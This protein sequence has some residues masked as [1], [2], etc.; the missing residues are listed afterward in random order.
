[1]TRRLYQWLTFVIAAFALALSSAVVPA[2]QSGTLLQQ[3]TTALGSSTLTIEFEV[4]GLVGAATQT[5]LTLEFGADGNGATSP[6]PTPPL[7][8]AAVFTVITSTSADSL[9][10]S[11]KGGA[12]RKFAGKVVSLIRLDPAG[13]PALYR[14][15]VVHPSEVPE[16]TKEVWKVVINGLPQTKT[17][18]IGAIKQGAFAS[19][20][21]IGACQ[22]SSSPSGTA[23]RQGVT[24][25]G[26]ANPAIG[27]DIAGP[28]DALTQTTL[29]LEFGT[30]GNRQLPA[31]DPAF[32]G[33][34]RMRISTDISSDNAS[35]QLENSEAAFANKEIRL[36]RLSRSLYHLVIQHR[37][38]VPDRTTEKW[39]VELTDMP[40]ATLRAIGVV[41]QGTV[42]S[43]SPLGACQDPPRIDIEPRSITAGVTVENVA[44]TTPD[45]F[46][47][48][49]VSNSQ[50]RFSPENIVTKATIT[51]QSRKSL[52]LSVLTAELTQAQKVT[53]AVTAN[54]VTSQPVTFEVAPRPSISIK[55]PFVMADGRATL[56]ITTDSN[57]FDLS[58]GQ[59]EITPP[60]IAS[61]VSVTSA[62]QRA[63]TV[64]VSLAAVDKPQNLSLTVTANNVRS[65]QATF[66]VRPR[67]RITLSPESGAGPATVASGR[68]RRFI[69]TS[70]EGFDLRAVSELKFTRAGVPDPAVSN[71]ALGERTERNA[72]LV[73]DLASDAASG[74]WELTLMANNVSASGGFKVVAIA[75]GPAAV[76]PGRSRTLNVVSSPGFDLRAVTNREVKFTRA[77]TE[78]SAISNLVLSNRMEGSLTLSFDVASD[79]PVGDRNLSITVG[80]VEASTRFKVA[81]VGVSQPVVAPGRLRELTIIAS[82]GFDLRTASAVKFTRAGKPDADFSNATFRNQAERSLTLSFDVSDGAPAGDRELTITVNNVD[83]AASFRLVTISAAVPGLIAMPSFTGSVGLRIVSSGGFDLSNAGQPTINPGSGISDVTV[84]SA[85]AGDVTLSFTVASEAPPGDR[86]LIITANNVRASAR[87]KLIR[88]RPDPDQM[89]TGDIKDVKITASEGFSLKG[90]TINQVSV[91]GKGVFLQQVTGAAERSV[92]VRLSAVRNAVGP[93]VVTIRANGISASAHVAVNRPPAP[94]CPIPTD[95]CCDEKCTIC[96]SPAFPE[97]CKGVVKRK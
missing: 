5:E 9:T 29:M 80:T 62:S 36:I 17:R 79:A 28:R 75:A 72:K 73:F 94:V 67:P 45:D 50:L 10:F 21:P 8:D 77:G 25:R 84:K 23:L 35:F 64:A 16:G 11:P 87:F 60:N 70:S 27:I 58:K 54:N 48:S 53:L 90:V 14:L 15:I 3:T 59:I 96:A 61:N 56:D 51:Q 1:M 40:T 38:G 85:T 65:R 91:S 43:L 52:T 95:I 74:D 12:N 63:L 4:F 68:A 42:A 24:F 66:E 57:V 88:L 19:M 97:E 93:A 34:A 2:Q 44:V 22:T 20:M 76:A 30:D 37:T 81:T 6:V 26:A 41:E 49:T 83:L 7:P 32:P 55:Q 69:V 92:V 33:T 78:D 71:F 82:E 86:E 47:L 46:D 39:R 18:V 89:E 13:S 31:A